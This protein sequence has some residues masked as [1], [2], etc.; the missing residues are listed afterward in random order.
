MYLQKLAKVSAYVRTIADAWE[1][2]NPRVKYGG[3]DKHNL[4]LPPVC[5]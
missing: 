4:S 2:G 3:S 5:L 1:R